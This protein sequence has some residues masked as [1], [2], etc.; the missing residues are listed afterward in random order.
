MN[1]TWE[2]IAQQHA[3]RVRELEDLV[4]DMQ[5]ALEIATGAAYSKQ[6]F[7]EWKTS[8]HDQDCRYDETD[9]HGEECKCD[10]LYI[11][12]TVEEALSKRI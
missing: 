6:S 7:D 11:I 8:V 4:K 9:P 12:E 2:E 10:G 5:Y 3:A 1:F